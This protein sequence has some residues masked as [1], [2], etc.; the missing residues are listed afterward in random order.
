MQ[1]KCKFVLN[2][3]A[4]VLFILPAISFLFSCQRK[5]IDFGTVPENSYTHLIFIDTVAVNMS[6]VL[7]DSFSTGSAQSFLFGK[8]KDP[9]LG[10]VSTQPF[11]QLNRPSTIP[12]I[13]DQAVFDSLSLIVRFNKYYYGDTTKTET[14]SVNELAEAIDLS[15]NNLIYNTTRVSTKPIPLGSKLISVHPSTDDTLFIRL[16]STKGQELFQKLRAKSDEM[17]STESFQYYFKGLSLTTGSGDSSVVYGIRDTIIMRVNYHIN[18]PFPDSKAIDFVSEI[19]S[20]AYNQILTDRN[21][22]NLVSSG[23]G[24]TEIPASATNHLSFTQPGTGLYLKLSFPSLKGVIETQNIIRLLKAELVVRPLR[25]SFNQASLKL[26]TQLFLVNTNGSNI[27]GLS[28]TSP[29]G[30]V[31]Y[32][33]PVIDNVFGLDNYYSF[34][35]TGPVNTMINNPGNGDAAFFVVQ[36]LA[37]SILKLDRI[38]AGDATTSAPNFTTQLKLS[39]LEIDQ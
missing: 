2:A 24:V 36:G 37:G 12:D 10:L 25:Q 3:R 31:Q 4:T 11:C 13:S 30:G 28:V 34:D 16:D 29:I 1:R 32:T 27:P 9:Y 18:D 39:V 5:E 6:T 14:I 20:V 35:V 33:N 38:I 22:T 26:P 19:N 21:G 7:T 17:N 8:Y 23:R 15:Y